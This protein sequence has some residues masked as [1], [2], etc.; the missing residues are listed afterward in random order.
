MKIGK[1]YK[2][3]LATGHRPDLEPNGKIVR[4]IEDKGAGYLVVT[5]DE[6][7]EPNIWLINE[8]NMKSYLN[9]HG[10]YDHAINHAQIKEE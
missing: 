3:C 7:T 8:K 5:S 10:L 6:K 9:Q 4:C 1:K 2:T